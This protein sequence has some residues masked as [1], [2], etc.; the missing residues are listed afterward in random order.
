MSR[1]NEITKRVIISFIY[2]LL[3]N[4]LLAQNAANHSFT[5]LDI[6]QSPRVTGLGGV[7]VTLSDGNMFL[8]NPALL[9]AELS[10]EASFNHYFYYDGIQYNSFAFIQDIGKTGT[11]GIGMQ[12]AGYGTIDSYDASGNPQGQESAGEYALVI[13]NSHRSGNF[14]VGANLK[15]AFS[16]I[17]GYHASAMMTDVGIIF[18]HPHEDM[19]AGFTIHNL[20]FIMR[21][22]TTSSNSTVPFDVRAG[23]SYKP[24]HM[25]FRFSI[26]LQKLTQGDIVYYNNTLYAG[27]NKPGNFDKIFSHVV[28]GTELVISKNLSFFGGYNHLIRR[29]MSLQQV[30]GG[31][32]FSY[33]MLISIKAFSLSYAGAFYHLAGGTH[34]LG[35]SVNLSSLYKRKKIN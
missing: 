3:G 34:H 27:Q 13:G 17:A 35:L 4:D 33:G 20:G 10:G 32:G 21:D 14:T 9:N 30:S 15:F 6:P 5:F 8:S 1:K 7:N 19:T 29:E 22:Y 25:P 11:W 2:I 24:R 28:L 31:A 23:F 16:N 26:T 18:R 12:Q